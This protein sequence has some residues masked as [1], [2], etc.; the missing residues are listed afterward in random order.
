[1]PTVGVFA[2]IVDAHRRVLCIQRNYGDRGWTLP[3]GGLESGE[4]PLA[5]LEREVYE[6]TGYVVSPG[7]LV[8]VY[9]VPWKDDIVLCFRATV[10]GRDPW[11]TDGE[12]SAVGFFAREDL[13]EPF[14]PRARRRIDDAFEG[15]S[16]VVHVFE[17]ED[18]G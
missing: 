17:A 2:V 8:G 5:A 1:M 16:G 13:P 11:E 12:I 18:S 3:G 15:R 14:S 9:S 7:T 6:E 10:L 4:S